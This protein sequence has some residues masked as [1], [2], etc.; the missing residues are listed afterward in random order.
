MD[1]GSE[2][3]MSGKHI[4]VRLVRECLHFPGRLVAIVISL[5]CLGGG[6]LYLTWIAKL[7]AEGPLVTGDSRAMKSLAIKAVTTTIVMM[8]GLFASRYL[9]NSVNQLLVQRLRDAAQRRIIA[10]RP[11]AMRRFQSGDLVS[12]ML[13]DAG[14]LSG[15]VQEVLR[16]LIGETMVI[17]G[18]LAMMFHIDWRLALV[19]IVMV[20]AVGALLGRLGGLIRR[21][22]AQAQREVGLLTATFNEQLGGLSTI[23][24]FQ[25]ESFEERRFARQ[26]SIYRRHVM[27]AEW[28]SALLMTV[29]WLVTATGLLAVVVY[30]TNQVA[31][32]QTTAGALFAFCV[33]AVQTA[34]P[35]RRLSEVQSLLQRAIA[36][37]QRVFEIIDLPEVETGG[38]EPLPAPVRGELR[39]EQV[40][41]RYRPNRAVFDGFQLQ[42]AAGETIALVASSGGGKSTLAGLAVRFIDPDAGR[43]TLDG[44]DLRRLKLVDLRRAVCIAEQEPFVFSGPLIENICYGSWNTSRQQIEQAV[45]MSGLEPWVQTLPH[46]IETELMEG[47]R[48]LSGGQKQRIS[49]ARLI[50]RDPAVVILDEATSALDSDTERLVM[51]EIQPWLA[52]RT[53]IVMAHRLSTISRFAR[54]AV[55]EDGR[56]VGDGTLSGLT[57]SCPAFCRLFAEQLTLPGAAAPAQAGTA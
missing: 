10:L 54:V 47:G 20:P 7:W 27:G 2:G 53:A 26:N 3:V 17:V 56:I 31:L 52:R 12:R 44:T 23:K 37:A 48:N 5:A 16:R 36:A 55:M 28:W 34:E 6:Q 39:F 49:L 50:V 57:E 15:F 40:G 43:I 29:V 33:Y 11:A 24:T 14:A 4:F 25:T 1:S 32:H 51:A 30:G 46:G 8:G 42:I 18:A 19:T 45:A 22:G 9:L 13:N 35:L 38:G 21:R 41:F